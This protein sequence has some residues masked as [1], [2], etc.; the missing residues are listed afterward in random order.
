MRGAYVPLSSG[1]G[2]EIKYPENAALGAYTPSTH[3]LDGC[4]TL[5]LRSVSKKLK[6]ENT[7]SINGRTGRM[8]MHS[9]HV[10]V[11]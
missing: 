5:S 6:I 8:Y 1:G 10:E 2:G 11:R 9:S 7:H 4:D 3:L